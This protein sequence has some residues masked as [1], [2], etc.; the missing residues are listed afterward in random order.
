[1]ALLLLFSGGFSLGRYARIKPFLSALAYM[2]I[3]V[4]LVAMTMALGG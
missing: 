4:F 2:A 3:G 1:V